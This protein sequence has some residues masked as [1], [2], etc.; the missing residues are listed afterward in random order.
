MAVRHK[1]WNFHNFLNYI[2][3]IMLL[4]LSWFFPLCP[5]PPSTSHSLRK[6]PHHCLSPWVMCLSSLDA[7]F[8]ILYLTSAWLSC[9]YLFVLLNPLT[10]SFPP[11]LSPIWQPSKCSPYPLFFLCSSCLLS[12]IDSIVHRYVFIAILFIVFT[13]F[14]N[15]SL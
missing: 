12:F 13:F 6:S 15:K 4:Q 5:S 7:P 10:S 11:H 9:D 2:L 3:L 14:L 8:P 1:S